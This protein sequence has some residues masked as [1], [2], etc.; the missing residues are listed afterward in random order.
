M[1]MFSENNLTKLFKR[2]F[3]K[4]LKESLIPFESIQKNRIIKELVEEIKEF[5]YHPSPPRDYIIFNKYNGVARIVPSFEAK[6]YFLYYTC[7]KFIEDEIAENRV[8]GTYGG[9]RLGNKISLMEQEEEEELIIENYVSNSFNPFL[10]SQ[11]WTDFQK[12][13]ALYAGDYEY[14]L[15]TDIANFYDSIDLNLLK[16]KIYLVTP[17]EKYQAVELLFYFLENWNKVFEG[18][19]RKNIGLPQDEF[20]DNSRLLANFYLQD[21][22]EEI[23]EIA[24]GMNIK[25]LRYADD[26]IFYSHD[27]NS[28][29]RILFEASKIIY[30][31]GL[32]MNAGKIKIFMKDEFQKYWAFEIFKK[33]EEGKY[34]EAIKDYFD[35]KNKKVEFREH[36]V[37]KKIMNINNFSKEIDI[38]LQ[39]KLYSDFFN[40]EFVIQLTPWHYSKIYDI[41]TE[42]DKS[43]FVNLL[44]KLIDEV[45]FNSFHYS[46][47]Y[48]FKKKDISY[49]EEKIMN[50]IQNIKLK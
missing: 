19:S 39:Y 8:E 47:L 40:K 16:R 1:N 28:L 35:F 31:L 9:W 30:K 23:K 27:K 2:T 33:I 48:F 45:F 13:A 11:N 10:W 17:K 44:K 25:Y 12:K 46:I 41:L 36:S 22:D 29:K 18:Y 5:T 15:F 37:L 20:G 32:H 26:M 3:I 21:F 6:D 43:K 49:D 4:K 42:N 24:D 34:N 50:T 7:V 38:S 14:M